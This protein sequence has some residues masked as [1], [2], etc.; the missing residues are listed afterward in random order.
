MKVIGAGFA[1]TGTISLKAALEHLGFGPCYHMSVAEKEGGHLDLW[2]A[3]A[4][5]ILIDWDRIFGGYESTV[6]WPACAFYKELMRAYPDAKVVLTVRDPERWYDSI[7]GTIY[8]LYKVAIASRWTAP[9]IRFPHRDLLARMTRNVVWNGTFDGRFEDRRHAVAA[10]E[11]HVEEVRRHVPA[12]RLLVF[13]VKDGWKPLCD[14][15]GVDVPADRPFP[16]LNDQQTFQTMARRRAVRT[17]LPVA[18]TV[19]L[20][21]AAVGVARFRSAR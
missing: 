9:F 18:A 12:D 8:P 2:D 13:E 16:H 21:G 14:F 10:F 7:N 4:R 20:V 3:A 19:G 15:L 1:R 11:R 17:L 5:G 6:D